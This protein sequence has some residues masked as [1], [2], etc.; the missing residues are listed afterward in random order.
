MTVNVRCAA[1]LN[2]YL[3]VIQRRNDGYHEI[4][5]LFQPVSLWDEL[6]L[7]PA[8]KGIVVTGDDPAVPWD[9][10]NLC[11]RAART[12]FDRM[13][14]GG[15]VAIEVRKLIPAG[16]GLGGGSSDAAGTLVGLNVL[17]NFRLGSDD[18][19]ELALEIGSDVPFFIGGRPA[20]GR[21][22]GEELET[23][24]GLPGGWIL[25]VKPNITISTAWAYEQLK[26]L[27][28]AESGGA[29]LSELLDGIKYFPEKKLATHNSF[30]RGI[31]EHFPEIAGVLAAL[32]R[33]GA[34]L[35]AL[36]GTGAACFA[37]FSEE[38]RAKEVRKRFTEKGFF[39]SIVRPVYQAIELLQTDL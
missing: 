35:C 6:F 33:E 14:F 9:E 24:T 29:K 28:T 31:V 2:L 4:E 1:K 23:V 25:I 20:I 13:G 10:S 26:L 27:L 39:L 7:S 21:G 19:A 15:G 11:H 37:L 38:E 22:R 17:M 12:L 3:D 36:S 34:F 32:K 8:P 16:A 18:L 30:E 5:T